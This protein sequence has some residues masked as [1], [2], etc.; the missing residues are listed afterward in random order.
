[1]D[2]LYHG[3]SSLDTL[4]VMVRRA[5]RTMIDHPDAQRVEA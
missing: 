5:Q 3:P 1:M 4:R 2:C